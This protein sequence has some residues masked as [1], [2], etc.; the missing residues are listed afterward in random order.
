M[1]DEIIDATTIPT[2]GPVPDESPAITGIGETLKLTEI[3]FDFDKFKTRLEESKE[4]IEDDGYIVF[5]PVLWGQPLP[6]TKVEDNTLKIETASDHLIS[7]PENT[8]RPQ[9]KNLEKIGPFIKNDYTMKP[10]PIKEGD[11]RERVENVRSLSPLRFPERLNKFNQENGVSAITDKDGRLKISINCPAPVTNL[12]PDSAFTRD[13]SLPVPFSDSMATRIYFAAIL[14]QM[15]FDKE[16]VIRALS[17]RGMADIESGEFKDIDESKLLVLLGQI[18]SLKNNIIFNKETVMAEWVQT[19]EFPY[20]VKEV[21]DN[22]L[23][24]SHLDQQGKI[25]FEV[26]PTVR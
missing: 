20:G 13:D 11:V 5:I 7:Y 6:V 25:S 16:F 2:A 21:Y 19:D 8:L 3:E 26:N 12:G 18:P 22:I 15:G 23:S 14:N 17:V 1:S 9:V 4:L 24:T 10:D